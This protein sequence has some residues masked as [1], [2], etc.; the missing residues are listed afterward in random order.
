[1]LHIAQ[2]ADSYTTLIMTESG[3][4]YHVASG[5]GLGFLTK[6]EESIFLGFCES[7]EIEVSVHGLYQQAL[8]GSSLK[9]QAE[10]KE[11]HLTAI[12]FMAECH[13]F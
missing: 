2:P 7:G 8:S 3:G 11:M 1:M 5:P 12:C 9:L 13:T 10:I 6:G 4:D